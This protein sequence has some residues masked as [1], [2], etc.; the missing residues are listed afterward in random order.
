MLEIKNLCKSF[1][2]SKV[3]FHL[4]FTIPTEKYTVLLGP[5]GCG[6][7]TLLQLISGLLTPDEGDI[8]LQGHSILHIPVQKRKFGFLFQDFALF[9]HLSV[10]EN[11]MFG[12]LHQ[13]I[14][15]KECRKKAMHWLEVVQ[16]EDYANRLPEQL[17][18]GQKQ[19]VALA[20]AM[21][22]EPSILLLDEPLSHVDEYQ[23][24]Q[25]RHMLKR[26]QIEQNL[27]IIHVTHDQKE[28]KLLA[29]HIFIMNQ[30][31]LAAQGKSHILFQK[32]PNSFTAKFLGYPNLFNIQHQQKHLTLKEDG[33]TLELH[34]LPLPNPDF[35]WV[36]IQPDEIRIYESPANHRLPAQLLYQSKQSGIDHLVVEVSSFHLE[37]HSPS[38]RASY[39]KNLYIEIPREALAFFSN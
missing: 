24:N 16:L 15:K 33:R 25:L 7:T 30:G 19:R 3:L 9:P 39:P 34:S 14:Q 18:G 13:G 2:S 6:K 27:T 21:A 4:N 1:Q 36:Y 11:I 37:I 23:R 10:L 22:I 35:Q 31:K 26:Y 12:P 32:P 5:S 20:R 29:E 8:L 28:A 17:S 38:R